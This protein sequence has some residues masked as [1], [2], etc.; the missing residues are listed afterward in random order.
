MMI[1]SSS[2]S[3]PPEVSVPHQS[4]FFSNVMWSSLTA[5]VSTNGPVPALKAFR[6]KSWPADSTTWRETIIPARS[7]SSDNIGEKGVD[8]LKATV[9]GST[10]STLATGANSP[11]RCEP[12]VVRYR[13][14]FHFT[15]SASKGVPS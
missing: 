13:S 11:L 9:D 10:T 7:T 8:R 15:D 3:L 14:M 1:L 5:S 4:G 6:V 12:S 2:G